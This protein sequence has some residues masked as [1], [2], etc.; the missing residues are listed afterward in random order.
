MPSGFSADGLAERRTD[1]LRTAATGTGSGTISGTG[2]G[3]PLTDRKN[4]GQR[5]ARADREASRTEG[6]I[7]QLEKDPAEAV[8]ARAEA[9]VALQRFTTTGLV[10]VALPE[11]TVPAADDGHWAATPAIALARAIES[12]LSS[13]DDTDA[14]RERVQRRLS[15]ELKTLQDTLSRHGNSASARM[16]EDGM[17]IDIV[18]QGRE[19]A[20]PELAEALATEV[21]ELTRILFAH[22]RE[23]LE[24][25]LITELAGTLQELIGAAERQ[26]RDMNTEL[27]DRPTSTGM[28]LGWCGGPRARLRRE[29]AKPLGAGGRAVPAHVLDPGTLAMPGG[30]GKA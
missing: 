27:D 22:E 30:Q 5:H 2:T 13:T 28:R 8:A 7:E 11:V 25:H 14:A 4:A 26:V 17:V 12:G 29:E 20:V 21:G 16:V 9:I 15:E 10:A 1:D 18:Y 24:T 3:H 23:I 6:R 19:R